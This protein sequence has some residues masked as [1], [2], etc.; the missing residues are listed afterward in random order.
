MMKQKFTFLSA[1]LCGI[2][3]SA[4]AMAAWSSGGG[5]LI[6][7]ADN[8]WFVKNT[9]DVNYCVVSDAKHFPLSERRLN[10]IVLEALEYWKLEFSRYPSPDMKVATQ[11]FHQVPCPSNLDAP[12]GVDLVFQFGLLTESQRLEIAN[13]GEYVSLAIR[14][15]YDRV[16][17]KGRGFIY[18]APESGPLKPN[19]QDMI[20]TPW[21]LANGGLVA[22]VITHELGH[23]FGIPHMAEK[24]SLSSIMNAGYPELIVH[25]DLA[26][27]VAS[28][29]IPTFFGS[30]GGGS[31]LRQIC[32]DE[33]S[34]DQVSEVTRKFFAL[35][36]R[37]DCIEGKLVDEKTI[38]ILGRTNKFSEAEVI[39]TID[40]GKVA[41]FTP[42]VIV[43]AYLW[44]E[45]TVFPESPVSELK[46]YMPGP[47]RWH[48]EYPG[49][50]RDY[51][52]STSRSTFVAVSPDF[53]RQR[54]GGIMENQLIIDLGWGR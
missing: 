38:H 40:L 32:T 6:K 31:V 42:E 8:P 52:G 18:V 23:V 45:Q 25:K 9:T 19:N 29:G 46:R 11:A 1:L 37:F 22:K 44:N 14:T 16:R 21:Q 35:P 34:G 13:P 2:G 5:S 53:W 50:Y 12:A 7:D 30:F 47:Q 27:H 24:Q 36:R 39:G 41:R 28:Q 17:L 54:I 4:S 10:E 48:V 15:D 43:T 49:V 33:E 3:F 20:E 51:A 26:K